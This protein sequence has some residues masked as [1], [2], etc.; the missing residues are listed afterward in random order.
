MWNRLP[1]PYGK[2][3][4]EQEDADEA[5]RIICG[6]I[7]KEL[8]VPYLMLRHLNIEKYKDF[9]WHWFLVVGYEKEKHETWIDD[10]YLWGKRSV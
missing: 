5:E 7:D 9:I 10:G 3:S 6:Q 4:T 1:D 2:N 8:P